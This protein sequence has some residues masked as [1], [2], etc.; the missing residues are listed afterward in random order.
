MEAMKSALQNAT[1][2]VRARTEDIRQRI[3]QVQADT[4]RIIGALEGE[5]EKAADKAGK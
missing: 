5:E 1:A 3:E 4:D 2:S